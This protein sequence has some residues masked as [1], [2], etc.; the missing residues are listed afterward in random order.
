MLT[1][2]V[3]AA[4]YEEGQASIRPQLLSPQGLSLEL[5]RFPSGSFNLIL[6]QVS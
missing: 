2:R 3:I 5:R 4:R 1:L 6:V